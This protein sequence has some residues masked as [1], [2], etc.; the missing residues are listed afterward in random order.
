QWARRPPPTRRSD[1]DQ[2]LADESPVETSLPNVLLAIGDSSTD[3]LDT[4][5][6]YMARIA[7]NENQ[8]SWITPIIAADTPIWATMGGEI[9]RHDLKYEA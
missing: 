9:S 7:D 3:E 1:H 6:E 4:N 8:F 2:Q 5:S